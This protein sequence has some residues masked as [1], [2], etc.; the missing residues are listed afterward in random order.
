MRLRYTDALEQR[1][2]AS[3]VAISE[4]EAIRDD[5]VHVRME[6]RV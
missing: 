1:T 3:S 4:G 2:I 6:K 5:G